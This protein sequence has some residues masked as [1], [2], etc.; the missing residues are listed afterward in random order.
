[1]ETTA[2]ELA[3]IKA[4]HAP[5]YTIAAVDLVV[6]PLLLIVG[7]RFLTRP[8]FSLAS[9]VRL[10]SRVLERVW[11][12]DS[13]AATIAFA[14]LYFGVFAV[15]TIPLELW[16][17]S[18]EREFGLTTESNGSW[19]F[20]SL[21]AHTVL[22]V[23][24]TALAFGL[25]GVARRTAKWWWLVGIATSLVLVISTALD[26]Y[27]S[28]LYVDQAPLR[29]GALRTKLTDTLARAQVEFGE[30]VVVN[31][32][33]KSVRVQAAFAGTGPT[34]TILLTDTLLAS[35]SESEIVAAVAHEAGHVSESRWPGRIL[36]PLAVFAL[37][38]FVEFL[39]RRSERS[40]WFGITK[41]GDVRVLPLVLLTFDL[42]MMV[43]T[44]VSAAFT[45]ER[46]LAADRLAVE[47]THDPASL[48]SLFEKLTR[49][50]KED[51]DPPRWYVLSGVTHPTV[52]ERVAAI[53]K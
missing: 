45:R 2:S 46:E 44:P 27:R 37:L 10:K 20:D 3:Q 9:R 40:G 16:S 38:A 29:P 28:K 21:K 32:S 43:A 18:H 47:L 15:L 6:W 52:R 12:D 4:Y 39:F 34:R 33:E 41:R 25:F 19:L 1:M 14:L 51:P 36:T 53:R 5:H 17:F 22:V 13:W 35:M 7:A 24:V 30:I 48:V 42:V 8:L 11:G 50:N 23:A 49:I 31:T 26:P